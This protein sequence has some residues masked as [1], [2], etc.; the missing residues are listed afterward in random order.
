MNNYC[1]EKFAKKRTSIK[2]QLTG[3]HTVDPN[4]GADIAI[5]CISFIENLKKDELRKD[6]S[7]G[8]THE[9]DG[10][11]MI[12]GLS[13]DHKS[14]MELVILYSLHDAVEDY[15]IR[16]EDV[17]WVSKSQFER[18]VMISKI[19]YGVKLSPED[20]FAGMNDPIVIVAKLID[21]AVNLASMSCFTD[22]K[23]REQVKETQDWIIPTG[24]KLRS[25]HPEWAQIYEL[26]KIIINGYCNL[27]LNQIK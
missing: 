19:R 14:K 22:Q 24:K 18:I 23:K 26:L 27:L 25:I 1:P 12:M 11:S 16:N 5:K 13:I 2:G 10:I 6:G 15:S 20:Y 7:P 8:I 21:R 4:C 17:P 3:I 9:Y